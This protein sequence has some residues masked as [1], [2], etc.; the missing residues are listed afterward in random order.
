MATHP[1]QALSTGS[2]ALAP[3]ILALGGALISRALL[4]RTLVGR[5]VLSRAVRRDPPAPE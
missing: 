5:T 1:D 2:P 3:L 4:G